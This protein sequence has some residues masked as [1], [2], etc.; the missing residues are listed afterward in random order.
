MQRWHR[1][2]IKMQEKDAPQT[3]T[4]ASLKLT[5]SSTWKWTIPKGNPSSIHPLLGAMLVSGRV[6]N[7]KNPS[8]R[9]N[10]VFDAKSQ[11]ITGNLALCDHLVPLL[12]GMLGNSITPT[13]W[14]D[15]RA[16][17]AIW[18]ERKFELSFIIY[19]NNLISSFNVMIR[20]MIQ[21]EFYWFNKKASVSN[22]SLK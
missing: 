22:E 6:I 4:V 18:A 17:D 5:Y 11:T 10:E 3:L 12:H 16:D 7:N 9:Q 20:L 13:T 2:P 1:N 14:I 19:C 21:N 8:K 15:I